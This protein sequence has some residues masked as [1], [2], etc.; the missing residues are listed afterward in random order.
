MAPKPN[1]PDNSL[2]GGLMMIN[3]TSNGFYQT[4]HEKIVTETERMK[5]KKQQVAP[6][7]NDKVAP[8]CH[9]REMTSRTS[10]IRKTQYFVEWHALLREMD[11]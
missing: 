7:C 10:R 11:A 2:I 6:R 4:H 8:Q 1:T 9:R 5:R 3:G